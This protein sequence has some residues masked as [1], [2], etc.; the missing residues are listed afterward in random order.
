ME[1]IDDREAIDYVKANKLVTANIIKARETHRELMALI[2]GEKFCEELIQKIEHL[3]SDEK[4][5]ARQKYSRSVKDMFARLMLPIENV[6]NAHGT[7]KKYNVKEQK[8][9]TLLSAIS[10]IRDGKSVSSFVQKYLMPAYH[11]D[12]A[13]VVFMEY[14]KGDKAPTPTIKSIDAIR[15]YH[16]K[17]QQL[18]VILFEPIV[19]ED[20]KYWRLV[21]DKKDYIII[22]SAEDYT[23]DAEKTFDHPFGNVP[24][25]IISDIY[26]I[27]TKQYLSPFHKII[28]TA[29]EYARDQSIKTIYKFLN[30]FP[31]HWRYVSQCRTCTGTGKK[32][33]SVCS[34]CDGHGYYKRKD[35]TDMVTLPVPD[36]DG[37]KIAPDI[38]GYISP[39][40]KTWDQY[41]KELDYLEM[42]MN[43]THW[44]THVEKSNNET[45]TGRWIDVQ[46]V[47]NKL[48]KYSDAAEYAEGKITEF[49]A[50]YVDPSKKKETPVSL[51][52]YG[53]R[54]IIE[55]P[56]VLLKNYNEQRAKGAPTVVLDKLFEEFITSKYMNDPEWLRTELVKAKVEPY[57]HLSITD[58]NTI[59]GNKEA[60]KKVFFSEW[61]GSYELTGISEDKAKKDF[62]EAYQAYA[63]ATVGT[64][65]DAQKAKLEAQ[66]NLRGSVGGATG[67]VGI[68]TALSQGFVSEE[69]A[70]ATFMEL[71]GFTEKV[72]TDLVSKPSTKIINQN[73]QTT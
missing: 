65:D 40:L 69:A 50:N 52:V 34:D 63:T 70:K 22:E 10:T 48:N 15:N 45:A 53:R 71:Y 54:Y 25:F 51:I 3:E 19:I 30:G 49:V 31:T 21:D 8:M 62:E 14:K 12:P 1:F 44:G 39:D 64:I 23:V 28:E 43:D 47:I 57:M 18:E 32:G 33:G 60:Q 20:K 42:K 41:N 26:D 66:A 59:F 29:K 35:V 11:N 61:W 36:K 67:V 68:L 4:A 37:Q 72:A 55:S 56:D 13:G 17:G 9:K 38:A 58:V 5:R 6:F 2:E 46:P 16:S 7:I 73:P 24:G 27:P